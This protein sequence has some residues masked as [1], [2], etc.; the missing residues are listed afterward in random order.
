M[1]EVRKRNTE[2]FGAERLARIE[3]LQ[4][5]IGK[6]SVLF[7]DNDRELVTDALKV[8]AGLIRIFGRDRHGEAGT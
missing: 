7:S 1:K 6:Y 2:L 8:H 4:K 3:A 5:V